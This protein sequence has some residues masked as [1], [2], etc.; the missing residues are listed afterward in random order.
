MSARA[1]AGL[2]HAAYALLLQAGAE[3]LPSGFSYRVKQDP[4]SDHV[5]RVEVREDAERIGTKCLSWA[6]FSLREGG[7]AIDATV[8]ACNEAHLDAFPNGVPA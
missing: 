2:G 7:A 4:H 1:T 5:V 3:E 8:R 6:T